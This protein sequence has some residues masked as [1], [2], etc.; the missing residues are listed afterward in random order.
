ML[1]IVSDSP[2]LEVAERHLGLITTYENPVSDDNS[3]LNRVA[4][5]IDVDKIFGLSLKANTSPKSQSEKPSI[6]PRSVRLAVARRCILLLLRGKLT[7]LKQRDLKLW[8]SPIA[9]DKLPPD[10]DAVYFGG[11]YPENFACELAEN[12]N[13]ACS[14]VVLP[15][16]ECLFTVSA[17]G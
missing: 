17:A 10:T 8:S 2:A 4:K 5:Q 13:L 6:S 7:A 9:G 16:L 11:G 15:N 14:C 1:S 3:D 12:V